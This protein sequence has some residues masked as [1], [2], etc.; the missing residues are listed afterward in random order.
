MDNNIHVNVTSVTKPGIWKIM[1]LLIEARHLFRCYVK[2]H[3]TFFD[4]YLSDPISMSH[5]ECKFTMMYR[6]YMWWEIVHFMVDLE[7]ACRSLK[8]FVHDCIN[9][10]C[11]DLL[12]KILSKVKRP[13]EEYC[14]RNHFWENKIKK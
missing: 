1:A 13:F 8:T 11:L 9:Y 12:A 2:S 4:M 7:V 5:K 14:V 6:E 3:K 10:K